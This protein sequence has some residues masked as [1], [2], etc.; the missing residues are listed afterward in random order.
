[1]DSGLRFWLRYIA[2]EGGLTEAIPDGHLVLLTE[3]L[4]GEFDLPAEL[5]VTSDPE[6]AHED[7]L[8]FVATGHQAP[9]HAADLV[10]SAGDAGVMALTPPA[11]RPPA[12][13]LLLEKARD[14]FPVDHGRIDAVSDPAPAFRPLLRVGV[15]INYELSADDHFAERAEHWI[16]V[17]SRLPAPAEW[18]AKLVRLTPEEPRV[19]PLS[20]A[21]V[22]EALDEAHR[23]LESIALARRA[24][25]AGQMGPALAAE[26]KRAETYYADQI[27]SIEKRLRNAAQDRTEVLRARLAA[28]G[29][30]RERRLS[31]IAEKYQARHEIRPFRLNLVHVPALRLAVDVLRGSRRYPLTLDYLTPLG[32]FAPLRCPSCGSRAPLVASKVKLGCE[33]CLSKP[34]QPVPATAP[35]PAPSP[36]PVKPVTT[37][38]TAAKPQRSPTV[39]PPKVKKQIVS[40]SGEQLAETFWMSTRGGGADT[41]DLCLP[42][43]PA[44]TMVRLYGPA[45]PPLLLGIPSQHRV[46]QIKAAKAASQPDRPEAVTGHVQA[47]AYLYRYQLTWVHH[48][49]KP[50][51]EEILPNPFEGRFN[52]HWTLLQ[53]LSRRLDVPVPPRRLDPV[54]RAV[55]ASTLPARGLF[56][57]LR[58]LTAWRRLDDQAAILHSHQPKAVAAALDRMIGYRAGSGGKYYDVA[59]LHDVAESAMRAADKP[60]AARLKL[61]ATRLW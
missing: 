22:E 7:H 2:A 44:A 5:T 60:L 38:A 33:S 4:A 19:A 51:V 40:R 54:E 31:E 45:G 6:A 52:P 34:A 47:S 28:T 13:H 42:C 61:S 15:L 35:A 27:T 55:W 11:S 1:M 59:N 49:G 46:E 48:E 37:K 57:T 50:L 10:L 14:Q 23:N 30:E 3:K 8:T 43:S 41:A 21:E 58:V 17:P 18:A 25:L 12:A 39:V 29:E 36:A 32:V 26:Q 53:Q 24:N 56:V 20:D 16:D 9:T